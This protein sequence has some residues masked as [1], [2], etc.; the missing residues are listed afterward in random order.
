MSRMPLL[1]SNY[2]RLRSCKVRAHTIV[3]SQTSQVIRCVSS[4]YDFI[5]K[6]HSSPLLKVTTRWEP[7]VTSGG[8]FVSHDLTYC[9]NAYMI[10]SVCQTHT[11]QN[12]LTSEGC[13]FLKS[14]GDR[15]FQI[16]STEAE[17]MALSWLFCFKEYW[18]AYLNENAVTRVTNRFQCSYGNSVRLRTNAIIESTSGL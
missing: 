15:I 17:K 1:Q 12:R 8:S 14:N 3:W 7:T 11:Q 10:A 2:I 5:F 4:Q 16:L 13:I 6:C 9:C 18:L